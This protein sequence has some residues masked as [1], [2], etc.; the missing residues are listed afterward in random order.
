MYDR[1]YEGKTLAFEASGGL[2]NAALVMR[3]RPTDSW[4]S[5]I[6]GEAIG[7]EL[8]GT[9][10]NELPVSE[11]AQWGDW[12]KRYPQTRVLSVDGWEHEPRNGYDRYFESTRTFRETRTPDERLEQKASVFAV[13]ID[14]VAYAA[15]HR[16]IEGGAAFDLDGDKALFLYRDPGAAIFASTVAVLADGGKERFV[17]KE[18]GWID[19]VS[20]T[21]PA[22]RGSSPD[23]ARGYDTFW[24]MWSAT[25]GE[26][27][28][29]D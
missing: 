18:G 16:R 14:C 25:H 6:T 19:T 11:K 20:G 4:W 3:D 22:A 1:R 13:V 29:L 2:W 10:L 24:Y 9:K 26:V 15:P 12:R 17:R 21:D 28:I 5:I 27:V 8:D 23:R 7:G